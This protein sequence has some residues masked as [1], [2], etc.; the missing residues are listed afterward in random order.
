MLEDTGAKVGG[1]SRR[2]LERGSFRVEGQNGL[3]RKRDW[4]R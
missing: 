4:C 3:E 1:S 2:G